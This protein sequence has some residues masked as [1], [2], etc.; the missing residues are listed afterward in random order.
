[1]DGLNTA[2]QSHLAVILTQFGSS[3]GKIWLMVFPT[4]IFSLQAGE[5][6]KGR[7]DLQEAVIGG[8]PFSPDNL[9]QGETSV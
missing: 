3:S 6:F 1:M 8:L 4:T 2:G 5:P 9:M 7:V